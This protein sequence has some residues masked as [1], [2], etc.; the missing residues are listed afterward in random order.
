[1]AMVNGI[2]PRAVSA[3]VTP[4]ELRELNKYK[5][6]RICKEDLELF[7][8]KYRKESKFFFRLPPEIN[9]IK[10]IANK[11]KS[12]L[13]QRTL[14]SEEDKEI[15]SSMI[16]MNKEHRVENGGKALRLRDVIIDRMIAFFGL[17]KELE[18][19]YLSFEDYL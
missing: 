11:C 18:A 10:S 14:I 17:E 2:R 3:P 19:Q 4:M 8:D 6:K 13:T 15:L 9:L 5:D 12:S 1:M 16:A 7:V